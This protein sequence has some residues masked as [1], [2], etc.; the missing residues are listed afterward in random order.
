[1]TKLSDLE[2]R[3]L[4]VVVTF[5]C[6][7]CMSD[8]N[9]DIPELVYRRLSGDSYSFYNSTHEQSI[10]RDDNNLTYLVNERKCVK[11]QELLN[12]NGRG[13]KSCS[14]LPLS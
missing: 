1:M 12:S 11:N 5:V 10:C 8:C 7:V 6:V 3:D 2:Q 4:F 14:L 9:E 13:H